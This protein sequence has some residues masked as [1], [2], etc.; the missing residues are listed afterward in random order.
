[1][2]KDKDLL[3]NI[4]D[5]Y[6]GKKPRHAPSVFLGPL[7]SADYVVDDIEVINKIKEHQRKLI[8]IDME[9][10]SIYKS[11][12]D[13]CLAKSISFVSIKSLCDFASEKNDNWQNYAMYTS[14]NFSIN[15]IKNYWDSITP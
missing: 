8:G 12:T 6:N 15:F 7:G 3:T 2:S 1:M 5:S 10:Y 13:C 9:T 4:H 14:S 11:C